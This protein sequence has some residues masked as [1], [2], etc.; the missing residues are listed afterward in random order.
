M[1]PDNM[2]NSKLQVERERRYPKYGL[3]DPENEG[4]VPPGRKQ[5]KKDRIDVKKEKHIQTAQISLNNGVYHL[6]ET[7]G[8]LL[9]LRLKCIL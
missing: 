6:E 5:Q 2:A 1:L 7:L 8:D 9:F 4:C 3:E